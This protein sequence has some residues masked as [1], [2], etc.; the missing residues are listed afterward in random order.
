[1]N[2]RNMKM[3]KIKKIFFIFIAVF[4]FFG[5]A[6]AIILP[7]SVQTF[8]GYQVFR[9]SNDPNAFYTLPR[10]FFVERQNGTQVSMTHVFFDRVPRPFSLYKFVLVAPYLSSAT[11]NKILHSIRRHTGVSNPRVEPAP[12]SDLY[13][14]IPQ[15]T[16]GPLKDAMSYSVSNR[17]DDG[18]LS[19]ADIN[20]PISFE[21]YADQ[22]LEPSIANAMM[23]SGIAFPLIKVKMKGKFTP[24]I[25]KLRFNSEL[26]HQYFG[27]SLGGTYKYFQWDLTQ[28]IEMLK[29][30]KALSLE[31][32]CDLQDP[33]SNITCNEKLEESLL[34]IFKEMHFEEVL[35]P[36][37]PQVGQKPNTIFGLVYR[38]KYMSDKEQVEIDVRH[39]VYDYFY[40]DVEPIVRNLPINRFDSKVFQLTNNKEE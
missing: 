15:I 38:G 5:N 20:Q 3:K 11:Q 6:N 33:S 28:E 29:K 1:M 27:A 21:F 16:F 19:I 32:E 10:Y 24:K 34:N 23:Q 30:T 18:K 26:V 36:V 35:T 8:E 37:T 39:T 12:I 22:S 9:D 31:V 40:Y 17:N 13:M 25:A 14:N 2:E 7:S 4:I